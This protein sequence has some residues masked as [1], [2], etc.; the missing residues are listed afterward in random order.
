MTNSLVRHLRFTFLI[1]II[2]LFTFHSTFT[3]III[4]IKFDKKV[5]AGY[6]KI[7]NRKINLFVLKYSFCPSCIII[8]IHKLGSFK[9]H[10]HSNLRGG[11][12]LYADFFYL[13]SKSI[14]TQLWRSPSYSNIRP[15]KNLSL[16]LEKKKF[17]NNLKLVIE[18]TLRGIWALNWHFLFAKKLTAF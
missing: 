5:C 18:R 15:R 8:V 2:S 11:V 10:Y 17:I 16:P 14:S 7:L 9:S 1:F 12:M 4:I 13:I 6:E 3:Q